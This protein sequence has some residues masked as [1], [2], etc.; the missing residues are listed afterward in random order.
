[1][2]P[3][4]V[5]AFD[6]DGVMFDS[7]EANRV[8]YNRILNHFDKPDMTDEQFAY[9][10]MHTTDESMVYLFSEEKNLDDV[11]A[12]RRRL[13]YDAF[14]KH[15]KIEPHLKSLLKKIRPAYG[16]AVATNRT[17]TIGRV[18]KT[19]DLD[20][21]FDLVVSAMDVTNPKPHPEG[22]L[23]ILDFFGISP[24]EALFVGDSALDEQ[25][26]NAAGVPLAAFGNPSL[27]ARFHIHSFKQLEAII[28]I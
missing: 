15:M 21:L 3:I 23:K 10:H 22:L 26:A 14:M 25:A 11:F 2:T 9:C 4:K 12:Y 27:N 6:C 28:G 24:D 16:T 8:Y 1:M 13:S 5:I 7:S 20:G 18:L 19:F 17:D